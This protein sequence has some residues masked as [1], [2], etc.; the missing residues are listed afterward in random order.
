[1]RFLLD[2]N[3]GL[4]IAEWLRKTGHNVKIAPKGLRNS[5]LF[6]LAKKTRRIF[7]TNDTDFLNSLLYPAKGTAG[8]IVFRIFP[9]T[10]ANQLKGLSLI[11]AKLPKKNLVGKLIELGQDGFK[12]LTK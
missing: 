11:L 2:E 1:M 6:E 4:K 10:L 12:I 7:L 9:P 5:S 3:V 8:R